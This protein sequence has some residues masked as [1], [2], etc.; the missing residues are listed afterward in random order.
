[1][2]RE[3]DES[4]GNSHKCAVLLQTG[5]PCGGRHG[6]HECRAR[7][8]MKVETPVLLRLLRVGLLGRSQ[9]PWWR[10][11]SVLQPLVLSHCQTL[12]DPVRG[13]DWLTRSRRA[14]MLLYN[15]LDAEQAL[16]GTAREQLS[17]PTACSCVA[18]GGRLFLG[19]M[20]PKSERR[21]YKDMELA[22][23]VVCFENSLADRG[24]CRRQRWYVGWIFLPGAAMVTG[25][26]SGPSFLLRWRQE[27]T[28]WFIAKQV[29]T[30]LRRYV[31]CLRHCSS[32]VEAERCDGQDPGAPSYRGG[33]VVQGVSGG[34]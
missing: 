2:G 28:S 15:T 8:K 3:C 25:V 29:A 26:L 4:C 10:R 19:P 24:A 11:Q 30:G 1:M 7:R 34:P 23:Q 6:A 14:C 18:R 32:G 21:R 31:L 22:L 33:Q 27:S 9:L 17:V 20:L 16:R 12:R 13:R 5:R